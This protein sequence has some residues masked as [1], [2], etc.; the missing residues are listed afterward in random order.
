LCK[1]NF[2]GHINYKAEKLRRQET[3]ARPIP[4]PTTEQDSVVVRSI[5]HP[6][7]QFSYEL[8]Q[9]TEHSPSGEANSRSANQEITRPL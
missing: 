7:N 9:D 2:K 5:F 8:S 4:K 6:D 1:E 3:S